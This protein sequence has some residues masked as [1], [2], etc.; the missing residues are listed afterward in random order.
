MLRCRVRAI[1]SA[2]VS[3]VVVVPCA[4]YG[5]AHVVGLSRNQRVHVHFDLVQPT[6]EGP[7]LIE[8]VHRS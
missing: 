2:R 6:R 4:R 5:L 1:G 8:S 7:I 3:P